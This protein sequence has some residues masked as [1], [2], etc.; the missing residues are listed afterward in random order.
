MIPARWHLISVDEQAVQQLHEALRLPVLFCRLLAQRGIST[1]EEARRFFR[2]QLDDLHNPFLMRD[3]DIAVARLDTALHKGERIL[4]Y[5]DYDVDGTTSVAVMY[6]FLS[7]FYRNLDYYLPDRDK[8]GYGV[9]LA[10]IE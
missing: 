9:S 1:K 3:M 2:P 6:A 10:G 8:E 7:G 5:G 4:L